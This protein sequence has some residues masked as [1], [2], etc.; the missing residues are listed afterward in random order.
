MT[1]VKRRQRELSRFEE[2]AL[3][4]VHPFAVARYTVYRTRGMSHTSAV[5]A[6]FC[7]GRNVSAQRQRRCAHDTGAE[8]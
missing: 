7:W 1:R 6:A 8:L 4:D 5:V 3:D 2:D